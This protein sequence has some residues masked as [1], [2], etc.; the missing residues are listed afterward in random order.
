MEAFGNAESP[1]GGQTEAQA[2][3]LFL[4]TTLTS[5]PASKRHKEAGPVPLGMRKE[6][7]LSTLPGT[8]QDP[9]CQL[10]QRFWLLSLE[11]DVVLC[12]LDPRYGSLWP[13]TFP[14]VMGPSLS[15]WQGLRGD[16]LHSSH[17]HYPCRRGTQYWPSLCWAG[18]PRQTPPQ[19]PG[20]TP[21]PGEGWEMPGE[22]AGMA[23]S[24]PY[25]LGP[26]ARSRFLGLQ[27]ILQNVAP[28]CPTSH[29]LISVEPCACG[30]DN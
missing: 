20:H 8:T 28:L 22:E 12:L 26:Q 3:E 14:P 17:P 13:T 27:P 30:S 1:L 5:L 25:P 29:L 9:L 4:V 6:P 24:A 19:M 23:A 18:K 21:T 7:V 15:L 10:G 2:L 11:P 16:C